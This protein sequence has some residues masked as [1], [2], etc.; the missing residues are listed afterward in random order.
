MHGLRLGIRHRFV[1]N[2]LKVKTV[3]LFRRVV[4][5]CAYL[6]DRGLN[7]DA[8]L[9]VLLVVIQLPRAIAINH[10][11]LLGAIVI[12]GE[13]QCVN[14]HLHG[15]CRCLLG[16]GE[17]VFLVVALDGQFSHSTGG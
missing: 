11:G 16:D 13:R 3:R 15:K 6:N 1:G 17:T 9:L 4:S 5:R 12:L 2:N 7:R 8:E 10:E 14:I